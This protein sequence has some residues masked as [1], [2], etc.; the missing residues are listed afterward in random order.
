V[1]SAATSLKDLEPGQAVTV[2][3]STGRPLG[4]ATVSPANLICARLLSRDPAC[5][6]GRDFFRRRIAAALELRQ[7]FFDRPYYRLVYGEADGLPGLVV[8][9]FGDVLVVQLATA[10]MDCRRGDIV[11]ALV[12][13]LHPAGVVLKN[14]SAARRAEGLDSS[15]AVVH[16]QVAELVPVVENEVRFEVSLLA[17]QKTGWF[18]DH[19]EGRA[20]LAP[21]CRGAR[22]LD[23]FSY[24]G[25]WGVQAAVAGAESVVCVDS[26]PAAL[27]L[28][29]HNAGLND[30]GERVQTL[31]GQAAAQLKQLAAQG[32][33]FDIIV[34]DPP[35]FIKR[36]KDIG[37]G[38]A[39]YRKLNQQA[40][41]V[42]APGGLLVTASCS[43]HLA[44]SDLVRL[45]G[46]AASRT[47]TGCI[48]VAQAGQGRDHPIVPA[49]PETEY[50]K[51]LFVK[52]TCAGK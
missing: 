46:Q 42:L 14:D 37:A 6:P 15:V 16:G 44:R 33:R 19:R 18:Y 5:E 34:L 27:E 11:A 51:T 7:Q 50:L 4:V 22:V 28:V 45:V 9:R 48:V 10:G 49:I 3:T 25:G 20:L 39:A 31:Q 26:S 30:C 36:R 1:D 21:F 52:A 23:V 24:V 13:L 29:G 35:A 8:D 41:R 12:D 47:G 38:Q 32:R 17:G 43:M 2:E 40:F